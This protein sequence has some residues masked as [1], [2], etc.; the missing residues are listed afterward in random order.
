MRLVVLN[1]ANPFS[2]VG[3]NATGAAE[4]LLTRLDTE[5][6]RRGHESIVMACEGSIVEGI[7]LST[8][9]PPEVPDEDARRAARQQ[10]RFIL[11]KFLQK[12][13]IDLIHLHGADFYEYLPPPGVPVLATLYQGPRSCPPEVFDLER[14]QTFLNC[15][16]GADNAV[17]P[18]CAYL[19]PEIDATDA[20]VENYLAIYTRLV[21]EARE[22][23]A[24]P[25]PNPVAVPPEASPMMTPPPPQS[26][27]LP[28]VSLSPAH[29]P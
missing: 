1:V 25:P 17:C 5:L 26:H 16:K 12:W 4:K 24:A 3:P 27:S 21:R 7:L 10:Y 22:L 6:V 28:N 9:R 11:Q 15:I 18:P 13:P 20:A 2:P 14:P 8:P 23:E 19:L 29:A